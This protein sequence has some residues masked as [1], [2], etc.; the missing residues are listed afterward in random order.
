MYN[1]I[2]AAVIARGMTVGQFFEEMGVP[3]STLLRRIANGKLFV[4]DVKKIRRVLQLNDEE[5]LSIFFE[6]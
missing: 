4:E 2:K 1:K 3:A 5:M 6:R